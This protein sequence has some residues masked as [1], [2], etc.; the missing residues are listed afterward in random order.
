[1]AEE[2][3]FFLRTALYSVFIGT[4]YWLV[5]YEVAGSVLL[6]FVVLAAGSVVGVSLVLA[7]SAAG[8]IVPV[9]DGPAHRLLGAAMRVVGFTEPGS[10][11]L[12]QPLE[13]RPQPFPRSSIWPLVA[14]FATLL[15]GLGLVYGPWLLLPGIAVGALAG[16]GWLT[17]MDRP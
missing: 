15:A 12:S 2:L 11:A 6:A 3:R 4:V 16:W 13:A 9:G 10:P 7:R 14:G 17:Q 1:M 5:S 8:E